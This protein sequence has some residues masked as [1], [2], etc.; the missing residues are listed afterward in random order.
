MP[1]TSS[2]PQQGENKH[3]EDLS[4]V[5]SLVILG[6]KLLNVIVSLI[7]PSTHKS[8]CLG[9]WKQLDITKSKAVDILFLGSA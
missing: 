3:S 9:S 5:T 8:L 4:G 2:M 1:I 6:R 7:Y